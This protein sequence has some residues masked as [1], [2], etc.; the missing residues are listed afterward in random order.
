[1]R[2]TLIGILTTLAFALGASGASADECATGTASF[3][4][5]GA[6]ECYE[7]GP[8]VT[9]LDVVA[10]GAPGGTGATWPSLGAG[11][12]GAKGARVSGTVAV[13][14]GQV[15]Y[16]RVGG[17]G[18]AGAWTK[19][20]GFAAGGF[21]GGGDGGPTYFGSMITFSGGGGGGGASDLRSCSALA[22][23][24]P[25][26][27]A[28]LESRL[29]IAAGGGGGGGAGTGPGGAGGGAGELGLPGENGDPGGEGR[30]G[31][32]GGGGDAAKGGVRGSVGSGCGLE[33]PKATDGQLGAGGA[34][35][36]QWTGGGGGGG[37]LY[38][39]GGGGGGCGGGVS[40]GGAGGGGSS[41]GP[42]GTDFAADESG[43]ASVAI[44]PVK[45]PPQTSPV[46]VS[47]APAPVP[48][49]V[50]SLRV[51]GK[52]PVDGRGRARIAV[53]CSGPEGAS[54]AG[55]V[56]LRMSGDSPR[57]RLLVGSARY[58]LV[59]GPELRAIPVQLNEDALRR[60]R[61]APDRRLGVQISVPGISR[62]VMLK[63][64]LRPGAKK[65]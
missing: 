11:G 51:S 29:L 45:V 17:A 46:V 19:S 27:V 33:D 28:S 12:I 5:A 25:G 3:S 56:Q 62:G 37:G 41:F 4:F 63:L 43:V 49:S 50:P 60:L 57:H 35:E 22:V 34:G 15:L 42:V 48:P 2:A 16:V 18:A 21:N 14:P 31:F 55:R 47:P 6:E 39:G 8:G 36:T 65:G 24:C 9:A 30:F 20:A 13:V 58:R 52:A 54:C 32:G 1:M 23:S 59:A 61:S 40:A 26:G 44:V 64:R 7:V 10:V 38:G 53:L